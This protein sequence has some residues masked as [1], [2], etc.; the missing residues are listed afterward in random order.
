M[1][2]NTSVIV[3]GHPRK[4][5]AYT[6]RSG[7][8]GVDVMGFMMVTCVCKSSKSMTLCVRGAKSG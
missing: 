8:V 3:E 6:N 4:P 1:Y 2:S 7:D 5:L